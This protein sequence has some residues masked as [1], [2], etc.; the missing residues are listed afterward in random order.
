MMKLSFLVSSALVIF[1]ALLNS[2]H[3]DLKA[4][5]K[6]FLDGM[7]VVNKAGGMC[8]ATLEESA[9]KERVLQA[10][11]EKNFT[12]LKNGLDVMGKT[13]C[14]KDA[15]IMGRLL[16]YKTK[17]PE[18]ISNTTSSTTTASTTTTTSTETPGEPENDMVSDDCRTCQACSGASDEEL[19]TECQKITPKQ[20]GVLPEAGAGILNISFFALFGSI[21]IVQLAKNIYY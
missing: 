6:T 20:D 2:I 10:T 9:L 15:H 19:M 12:E 11:D 17:C 14:G 1:F 5:K 21:V 8:N 16:C 4:D 7:V 18:G 13:F 3:A